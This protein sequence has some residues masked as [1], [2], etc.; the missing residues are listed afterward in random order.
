MARAT[1][2][3]SYHFVISAI[4]PE[5]FAETLDSGG[6]RFVDGFILIPLISIIDD[7]DEL[8]R[9]TAGIPFVQI[10][11]R[12][13]ANLPS[14]IYDQA[15]GARLATQ[16]LID[17][18]HQQIAE[19]SGPLANYDAYDRHEGWIATMKDNHLELGPSVEGDFNIDSGYA[20][21]NQL[22]DSGIPFTAIFIANDSM[23][24]G[25]HT[26]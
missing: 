19:I 13:G 24:F 2:Q 5:E 6:S 11:A 18:G 7:Y 9:L 16:H 1:N 3:L 8:V 21:M 15:Q 10:G 14:V 20:A 26:A 22:L 17:L 12:L 4:A 23:T 25:A